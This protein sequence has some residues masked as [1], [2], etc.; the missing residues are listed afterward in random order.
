MGI[1]R[2][3]ERATHITPSKY[4]LVPLACFGERS[5][6]TLLPVQAVKPSV[7]C[8]LGEPHSSPAGGIEA[9]VTQCA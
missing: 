8:T 3:D 2:G 9:G 6:S 1:P 5:Y 4:H 7:S